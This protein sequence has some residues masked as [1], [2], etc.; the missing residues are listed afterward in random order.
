LVTG[1]AEFVIAAAIDGDGFF[2]LGEEQA[3]GSLSQHAFAWCEINVGEIS[4]LY[5]CL[6]QAVIIYLFL[7]VRRG[8]SA[9]H[10]PNFSRRVKTDYQLLEDKITSPIGP[11]SGWTDLSPEQKS[12][13][14]PS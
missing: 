8:C 1:R 2:K 9:W 14:F 12:L 11:G 6:G 5:F 3:P 7:L 4:G 13:P 10:H